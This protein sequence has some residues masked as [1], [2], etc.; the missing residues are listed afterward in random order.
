MVI[1][2][3]D[4]RGVR[5]GI[6]G[7]AREGLA[8]ASYLCASGARVTLMDAKPERDLESAL[9]QLA[10][11]ELRLALGGAPVEIDALDVLFV[12]PGVPSEAKV[13][14]QAREAGI[15][16]SSEPRLLTQSIACPLVG[17]TG[18]SGKSTTTA[19]VGRMCEEQG[20]D[21]WVGGN[22][23]EPL[24]P[25]LLGPDRPDLVIMELSSFQLELFDPAYQGSD[26]EQHR[27][28]GSRIIDLGGWSPH[29]AAIT[30]VTPNHLDRHVTMKAYTW[31]KERILAYQG[32]GDWAVLNQDDVVTS[33]LAENVRGHLLRFSLR[34]EIEEGAFLRDGSLV[35]RR[36]GAEEVLCSARDVRLRGRHNL[37]NLLAAACCASVVGVSAE[38]IADIA[39]TF[40]GLPHRLEP[41]REWGGVLFV[42]DSIATSPERAM[43]AMR[44]YDEP[45]VLLAGGRD[46][47]LPWDDW[48]SLALQRARAVIAFGEAVPTITRAMESAVAAADPANDTPSVSQV[49]GLEEAVNEAARVARPGDVVLLSPGGTSFDAFVN[50][51]ARGERFRE[52]VSQL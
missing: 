15:P 29:V 18:S 47:H 45:L 17:I 25:R 23:G 4:W 6:V 39:R 43:A 13:V 5:V 41:V 35:L 46:K 14:R 10:D 8:L 2:R 26:T 32:V 36:D 38:V 37:A 27:S 42:N 7:A 21:V 40:T 33:K 34:P 50:F 24:T 52:L 9:E 49:P 31:A 28:E 44:A 12:S 19:L 3:K 20:L 51:E 1:Q 30:N 16:L 11:L 48:A 22:I